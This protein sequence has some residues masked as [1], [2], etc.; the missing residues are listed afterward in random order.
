MAEDPKYVSWT[1]VISVMLGILMI[2]GG[3]VVTDTRSTMNG[4]L[5]RAEYVKDYQRR[6]DDIAAIKAEISTMQQKLEGIAEIKVLLKAHL[7]DK[8]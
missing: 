1:W 5:D 2:L 8:K 6:N 7:G 3:F 4:K